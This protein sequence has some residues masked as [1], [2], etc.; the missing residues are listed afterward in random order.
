VTDD[1]TNLPGG[2]STEI[3]TDLRSREASGGSRDPRMRF[4]RHRRLLLIGVIAAVLVI[5][6]GISATFNLSRA[7]Q[8][9]H[10]SSGVSSA[11][12]TPNATPH[13]TAIPTP[14]PIPPGDDWSQYRFDLQGTG[15]NP[16]DDITTNNVS[17]LALR[18]SVRTSADFASTPAVVDGVVYVTNGNSLYAF[19]QR[20]SIQLWRFDARP[21]RVATVS[22]SVAVD[23]DLH[24]AFYGNPDARVYAVDIRTGHEVW[25]DQLST[26]PGAYV[27]SS[28][29]VVNGK[30]YIGLSSHDDVP[31]V[32]GA[33]YALDESTGS[34]A[35]VHYTV[36]ANALGGTVWSSIIA[37]TN[38][39]EL[40]ATT[41]NPCPEGPAFAESD[42]ILGIDWDDG[43]T[44]WQY[45]AL[46]YDSCDCDFGEGAVDLVYQGQEYIIAGNKYGSVFALT[47]SPSGGTPQLAWS[48]RISGYG[49]LEQGGIFEPPTYGAGLV[50]VAGGPTL[51]GAC[52]GGG[53]WAFQVQT[54]NEVW[55]ACTSGQVVGPAAL[56]NGVLFVPQ[57]NRLVAYEAS[58]GQVLETFKQP[59]ETWGGVSIS[60]GFVLDGTVSNTLYCY[61]LPP[62]AATGS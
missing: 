35:W 38:L 4:R 17:Q 20:T 8:Q 45:Q 36:P 10:V 51:D 22:S 30:V 2:R 28:P 16:E 52:T 48:Q 19:N 53:L 60:H 58:T 39:H 11:Q 24:L 47:R 62:E 34:I 7:S 5:L 33:I 12:R 13:P 61:A 31:C 29:L 57:Q 54:G 21:Q 23:A 59:G 1:H 25:T 3:T 14:A 32:R 27:W 40:I 46:A 9:Q 55:R 6:V 49:Y 15:S 42:S 37:N 43:A 18:W 56:T 41:G 44:L 50:F 26:A